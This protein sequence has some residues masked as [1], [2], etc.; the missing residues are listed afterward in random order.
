MR[1]CTHVIDDLI[2]GHPSQ[3]IAAKSSRGARCH[4]KSALGVRGQAAGTP[5]VLFLKTGNSDSDLPSRMSICV[6]RA[7][8]R[9]G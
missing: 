9:N 7:S 1:A 3:Y 6:L 8:E 4:P 5:G 2:A